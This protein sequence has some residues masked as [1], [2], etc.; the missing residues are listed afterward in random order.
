MQE[1]ALHGWR[2]RD[3]TD[4]RMS[5]YPVK[6]KSMDW[7][8]AAPH[9]VT[10]GADQ[11]I[12]WPFDGKDGPMGRGPLMVA[13]RGTVLATAVAGLPEHD[14]V[15]AG[16]KDGTILYSTLEKS[17]EP[18][19]ISRQGV[20]AI[21]CLAVTPDTGWLFAAAEDGRVLWAPLGAGGV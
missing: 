8:G 3:K 17:A 4:M 18:L 6:V 21:T 2:L 16:Y 12:C 20:E 9:L 15:V 11:A 13:G 5:G 19:L 7:V 10:S 1:N 14:A